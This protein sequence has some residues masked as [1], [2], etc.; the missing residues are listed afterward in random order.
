M[1]RLKQLL[2]WDGMTLIDWQVS[3]MLLAGVDD[4]VVVLGHEAATVRAGLT[5]RSARPVVNEDY[6]EGRA[7][8]LRCG[9][10]AVTDAAEAVLILSVDQP[11]PAWVSRLLIERWRTNGAAIALPALGGHRSHPVL[12]SGAL[13][14]ELRTVREEDF[15]LRAVLERHAAEIDVLPIA[16]ASIDKDLNTPADYEAAYAAFQRGEWQEMR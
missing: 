10:A 16:N 2:P 6:R 4:V 7:S 13:L 1:G 9:A 8:S 11:R 5:N 15:G 3:Q 14:P 12:I